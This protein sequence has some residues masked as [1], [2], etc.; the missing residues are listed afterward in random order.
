MIKHTVKDE[1]ILVSIDKVDFSY[2]I[3]LAKIGNFTDWKIGEKGTN[4]IVIPKVSI[5]TLQLFTKKITDDAFILQFKDIVQEYSP[6]N[7]IDWDETLLAIRIQ[8][9]YNALRAENKLS[10]EEI[11]SELEKQHALR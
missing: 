4:G 11:I 5:W 9:D 3:P 8:N 1:L 10:E 7:T 6:K 2:R